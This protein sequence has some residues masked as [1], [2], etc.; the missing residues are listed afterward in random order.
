MPPRLPI[1]SLCDGLSKTKPSSKVTPLMAK[2]APSTISAVPRSAP[3]CAWTSVPSVETSLTLPEISNTFHA[4][5]PGIRMA[6]LTEISKV[7]V[8]LPPLPSL[9]L[10]VKTFGPTSAWGGVPERAPL[11]ATFNQAGPVVLAKTGAS[12][13]SSLVLPASVP[14]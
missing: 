3:P 1:V 4:I 11:P 10:T 13:S 14:I 2:V 8:S 6:A 9:T 5:F 12:P 7:A